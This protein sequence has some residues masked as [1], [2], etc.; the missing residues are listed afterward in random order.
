MEALEA[1]V[2][3]LRHTVNELA[4]ELAVLGTHKG[5][6]MTLSR[7][8]HEPHPVKGVD[9]GVDDQGRDRRFGVAY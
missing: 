1:E 3:A 5:S 7:Q 6:D 9:T 2:D 4:R 8:D